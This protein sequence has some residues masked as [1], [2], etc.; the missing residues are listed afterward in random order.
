MI[1]FNDFI[2]TTLRG[3][4]TSFTGS[5][6]AERFEKNLTQLPKDWIYRTKEIIY[7]YNSLG[8]RCKE[9]NELDFDNY[10][11]FTGCSHTEGVGLALEDTY[12][13]KIAEHLKTDFS[14]AFKDTYK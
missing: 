8:F 13:Y 14:I 3:Q 12:P 5:D 9:P 1:F 7:N 4:E 10:V 6:D 2:C 11:L